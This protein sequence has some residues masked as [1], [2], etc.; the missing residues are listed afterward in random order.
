MRR[1]ICNSDDLR[2]HD[3]RHA[4]ITASEAA[5]VLGRVPARW[6]KQRRDVFDDKVGP[7]TIWGGNR[8]TKWGSFDEPQILAAFASM[9]GLRVR[10]SNAFYENE[11]AE[12][13][14]A[15]TDAI[16][17]A[18]R[19][20]DPDF[21]ADLWG[22]DDRMKEAMMGELR[23][24]QALMTD[25]GRIGLGEAKLTEGF[26]AKEWDN[27][28]PDH[29]RCQVEVQLAVTEMPWAFLICRVGAAD[30]RWRLIS[31]PASD[32]TMAALC[33]FRDE[34][35]AAREREKEVA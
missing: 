17:R 25:R 29:Y 15:T 19:G 30:M 9:T 14:G 21:H 31:E 13:V 11:R 26:F 18:P 28:C 7:M 16:I 5:A 1:L 27:G 6:P 33:D 4:R 22:V 32:E 12:G 8:R 34:I 2:W 20:W 23:C 35:D 10:R 3:E 24:L